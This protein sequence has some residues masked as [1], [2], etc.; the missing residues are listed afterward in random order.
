MIEEKVGLKE[1]YKKGQRQRDLGE[2][3]VCMARLRQAK[4]GKKGRE[5]KRGAADQDGQPRLRDG[6]RD[7]KGQKELCSQNSWII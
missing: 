5:S 1:E 4:R 2:S 3:R 6:P 7:Q